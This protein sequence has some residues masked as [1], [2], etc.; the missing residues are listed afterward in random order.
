MFKKK[1]TEMIPSGGIIA[2]R[3]PLSTNILSLSGITS[4]ITKG[5]VSESVLTPGLC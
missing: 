4:E 5:I 3:T 2:K 1:E